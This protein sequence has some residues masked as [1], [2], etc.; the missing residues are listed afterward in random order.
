MVDPENAV[1]NKIKFIFYKIQDIEGTF[2][3]DGIEG[4]M[5]GAGMF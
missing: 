4:G 3:D 1:K 5:S 2:N